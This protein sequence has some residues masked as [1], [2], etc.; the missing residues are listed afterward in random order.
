MFLPNRNTPR[1]MIFLLDILICLFSLGSA[2]LLRFEFNPPRE[3][4]QLALVFL[5][6][7]LFIRIALFYFGKTYA[8][9]IRYT[10][11]QDAQR[12]T[13]YV[14]LGSLIFSAANGLR[15]FFYDEKYFVPFS[16]IFID[17]LVTIFLMIGVRLGVKVLYSELKNPSKT[18]AS[19]IIF[20]AGESGIITKRTIDRDSRSGFQ[21]V[22]FVDDDERKAGKKLENVSIFHSTKTEELFSSGKYEQLIISVQELNPERKKQLIDLALKHNVQVM[23]VPPVKRWIKGELSL[24]QLREVKIEDLLGRPRIELDKAHLFDHLRGKRIL[25]TG[26]AGSIGSELVRQILNYEP[27]QLVLLDQAETPMYELQLELALSYPDANFELVI[28]DVRQLHRLRRLMEHCQAQIV[29][30]AAAYKHVPLMEENPS[31]AVLANVLGSKNLVDLAD[32]FGVEQFVLVS[33]DKAVNPTSVMGASKRV[34]EIYAQSKNDISKTQYIT[35]RF[36]NVLGSNGSVIPLFKKQID[37]GGPLTV[38]HP[39]VTRY[40]MTIPEAA[41]LVLEAGTLGEGGE[42]FVFDMGES[43][44]IIDLAKNMVRLS[45]LELDKDIEIK[46][47]GLRPGE[48]LYEELLSDQENTVPTHHPKI[49]KAQVRKYNHQEVA[50]QIEELIGLFGAQNNREIVRRIKALVPEYKSQNSSFSELD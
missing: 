14:L 15:F 36:G 9:I 39:E 28:G 18:K 12:I 47:S 37:E 35:T 43:V 49:L 16:I 5:P 34:A 2:Y 40:F 33:T 4:I 1:W 22:A 26:A 30:H 25:V 11:T 44:K 21:V 24:R 31:E 32:E 7:F 41:Q 50:H 46:I 3:E 13:I 6:L 10:G 19:V 38:T 29:F 23:D 27:A 48:K 42:I 45:G 17:F 20:G 8:G